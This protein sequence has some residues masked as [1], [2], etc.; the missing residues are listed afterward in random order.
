MMT[1]KE[2]IIYILENNLENELIFDNGVFLGGMTVEETATK[3]KTG[4]ATVKAWSSLGYLDSYVM[5]GIMYILPNNKYIA[6]S[7]NISGDGDEKKNS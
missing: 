2:L 4:P 3:L 5:N 7:C 1:G 6:L